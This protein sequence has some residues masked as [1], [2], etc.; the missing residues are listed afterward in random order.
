MLF[1]IL[2]FEKL[3][4]A[5]KCSPHFQD[6]ARNSKILLFFKFGISINQNSLKL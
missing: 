2:V 3:N 1:I 4:G 5:D 6:S